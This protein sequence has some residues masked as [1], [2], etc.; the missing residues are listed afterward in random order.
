MLVTDG[1]GPA[2]KAESL[3]DPD[4][5][6]PN[7]GG[8]TNPRMTEDMES[9][10]DS[11]SDG[12]VGFVGH[13]GIPPGN[14]HGSHF[15][16]TGKDEVEE[17]VAMMNPPRKRHVARQAEEDTGRGSMEH[18]LPA[19]GSESGKKRKVEIREEVTEK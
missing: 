16:T 5:S 18:S 7:P 4:T 19:R 6:S 13:G 2:E 10:V 9:L 3:V 17:D 8:S 11:A 12:D 1:T 14:N 15:H